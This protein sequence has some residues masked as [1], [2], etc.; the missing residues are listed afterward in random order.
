MIVQAFAKRL[1]DDREIGMPLRHLQQI[2]AAQPLQP[3]RRSLARLPLRGSSSDR[4]AF[5]RK[6]R[7][8]RALSAS[9]SRIKPSTVPAIKPVEQIEHRLVG[10]GQTDQDAVVVVQA[11][12]PIA[13]PLAQQASRAS[14]NVRC[15][16]PPSGLSRITCQS[17]SGSRDASIRSVRSVGTTPAR[18]SL[19][20][21]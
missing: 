19:A 10:V 17:P 4:A 9:S 2:A 11:L 15:S 18:R 21:T 20:V 6:R 12:R 16:G 8:N 5:C 3:Q 1:G 14:R 7:A 13:E